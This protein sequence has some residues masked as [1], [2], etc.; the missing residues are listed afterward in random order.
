MS[1]FTSELHGEWRR[2]DL[3]Q[4]SNEKLCFFISNY[5][6]TR[7]SRLLPKIIGWVF[8]QKYRIKVRFGRISFPISL[9]DVNIEKNGFN[10]VSTFTAVPV[11]TGT[12]C[13]LLFQ[14]IIT[15]FNLICFSKLMKSMYAAVFS[16]QR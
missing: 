8:I 11:F 7:N 4:H 3:W 10:I 2:A 16:I 9:K 1:L 6:F 13:L 5:N 15:C 14:N 12:L